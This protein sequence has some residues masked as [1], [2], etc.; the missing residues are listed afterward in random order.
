MKKTA[1]LFLIL[2]SV[3][4]SSQIKGKITDTSGKPLSFVSI[5]LENTVTGSTSNDNG[6]YVLSIKKPGTYSIYF[7]FLGYKTLKK[8]VTI[9]SFPLILNATLEEES[10]ELKEILISTKDNP[11]NA[12]IRNVIANKD[13]I[14]DKFSTYTA[15][16]YS[17]GLY[18]IKD[19]P[20][21]FMGRSLGDFGGGLDSTRSGIIYL[22]E[23]ISEITY[24]KRPKKFKEKITASKVSGTDNGP[25]FNRAEDANI[26]F[27]NNRVELGNDLISPLSTNAFSYYRFKLVGTFYTKSGKLINKIKLLPKRKNDPVFNGNIYIVEDDWAIYGADVT[28]TG[29]QANFPAIDLLSLKQDYNY[30]EEN[31]SWV[32]I[33]QAIGFQV[34]FLGFKFDG[35]FSSAYSNYNFTPNINKNMFSNEVLTF[36]K[37]ATK[38]DSVYWEKIRPVPL[39]L[40]EVKDYTIKDSIKVIRKSKKYLDSLDTKRN[41]LGWFDPIT[42]YT[43]LNSY[44]DWSISYNGPLLKTSFNPVQGF[45]ST[46]GIGYFKRQNDAGKWWNAGINVNYG[47]AD[48][49]AR[50][51][52]FFTKKWNNISRP[53]VSITGGV[54]T[55]QFNDR[56]SFLLA[57]NTFN[58]LFDKENYL[59]IYE[60]SFARISYSNEIKNGVF[61]NTSLEYANRKPLFNTTNYSFKNKELNYTSNNPLDETD[62]SN[63]AFSEHT[64]A[65]LNI[66]VR[67]VFGQKYLSYPNRK[68]NIGNEKYPTFNL[69]YRKTFGAQNS[70]LN[71]DILIGRLNQEI[72]TGNYGRLSY[73]LRGGL[74]LKKK[75]I[76]FMDYFHPNGNQFTFPL[77]ISYTN[78]FGLLNYYK[79]FS[80]DQ[81]AEMHLQHNFRGALLS[82]IPLMNRL[83]FHLVAGGKTLFTAERKPYSEY[84][85]GLNNIGWG[86]WR[87]LR[88][89]Y[90]RSNFNGISK[91]GWL[92]GL[93]LFN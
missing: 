77:D 76:A 93:S 59:K 84:S 62:Y 86:K 24:Q 56:D 4:L 51:T 37:T 61:L 33:S 8:N 47:F 81:Y 34:N 40:E 43:F 16:F 60:K 39:T 15:N 19:A 29:T 75:Q 23:T 20:N 67:F 17:R 83:N 36:A 91:E 69:N 9:N 35:K 7:Q 2:I 38:K 44:K 54:T 18:K 49:R 46:V 21:K 32:L 73:N 50:P 1:L 22:S 64:I 6:D 5:Y 53:R 78:S 88:I 28:V 12:I 14:T 70:E 79:I 71:S 30:S 41:K 3:S 87:F 80:N 13:K 55:A 68:F 57:N 45:H 10:I 11:A 82:K 25:S 27:Y 89:D 85:V 90:V 42:G 63:A 58:A 74:F 92:F 52:I 72:N 26:N 65:T 31:D 48:K 66:G